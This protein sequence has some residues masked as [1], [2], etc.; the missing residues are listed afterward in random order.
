MFILIPLI[1]PD[2]TAPVTTA[3]IPAKGTK[4]VAI[5]SVLQINCNEKLKKG[6][7][8]NIRIYE[9]NKLKET[10]VVS[11]LKVTVNGNSV[12][13]VPTANFSNKARIAISID[14]GTFTDT[15]GNQLAAIDSAGWSFNTVEKLGTI[16]INNTFANHIYPNPA[17]DYLH[18][19]YQQSVPKI[20]ILNNLGQ[21]MHLKFWQENEGILTVDLLPLPSGLYSILLDGKS[22]QKLIKH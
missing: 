8:G 15:A 3:L 6:S 17:T 7:A 9:N 20:D 10:I 11:D 14:K 19:T 16:E 5:T 18:I 2:N 21:K 13:I 12:T 1:I 4:N 22:A